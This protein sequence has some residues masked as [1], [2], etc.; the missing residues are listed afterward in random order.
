VLAPL[1]TGRSCANRLVSRAWHVSRP[2]GACQRPP[3]RYA[4]VRYHVHEVGDVPQPD[5]VVGA[6]GRQ[7]LAV[8]AERYRDGGA[9]VAGEEA[10]ATVARAW[11]AS[12]VPHEDAVG[13]AAGK[14][15]AVRAERDR[16]NR[17]GRAGKGR[18]LAP[19]TIQLCVHCQ[20]RPA[21][22]WVRRTGGMVVRRP[23][24]MSCSQDLDRDDYDVIPFGS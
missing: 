11:A 3:C 21:G 12:Q 4:Q 6:A 15:R 19:R 10:W 7:G 8:R 14:C 17:A 9:C 5:G 16:V 23:W 13:T 22:F 1:V 20:Q 2:L 24:C 18:R